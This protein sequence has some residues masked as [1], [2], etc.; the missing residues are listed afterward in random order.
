MCSRLIIPCSPSE[1]WAEQNGRISQLFVAVSHIDWEN[2]QFI[3]AMQRKLTFDE[4][5]VMSAP[6]IET[7]LKSEPGVYIADGLIIWIGCSRA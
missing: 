2:K 3:K 4:A 5:I 6:N 1:E 7:D